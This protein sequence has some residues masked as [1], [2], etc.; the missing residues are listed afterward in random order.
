MNVEEF[1]KRREQGTSHCVLDVREPDEVRAAS[2]SGSVNIPMNDVAQRLAELPK[3][4]EI[5]VM[6]A[7]GGRS[8]RVAAFLNDGG[9]PKA[10]NL[11]GGIEAWSR[12]IDPGV[13]GSGPSL[14]SLW[15]TLLP[16]R[17]R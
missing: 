15:R 10:V 16:S 11:E 5:V 1:K 8:A 13:A 6:C 17:K 7:K 3:D 14:S 9:F 12:R 4:R 2:I